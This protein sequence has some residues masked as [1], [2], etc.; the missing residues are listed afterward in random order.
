QLLR[1]LSRCRLPVFVC[2]LLILWSAFDSQVLVQFGLVSPTPLS[3]NGSSSQHSD[4]DEM[5]DLSGSTA[6]QKAARIKTRLASM[7]LSLKITFQQARHV[8]T[9]P[10]VLPLAG[11]VC[12]HAYRNGVGA[13]LL[14]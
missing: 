7:A 8:L 13:P 12:E 9:A 6:R 5:L 4:D 2:S 11:L 14:C 3:Q 10:P 1:L